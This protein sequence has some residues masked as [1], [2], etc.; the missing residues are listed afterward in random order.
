MIRFLEMHP[1]WSC[2]EDTGRCFI[3]LSDINK[4]MFWSKVQRKLT[5]VS[6][7][8]EG[9]GEAPPEVFAD[10]EKRPPNFRHIMDQ[11]VRNF[12]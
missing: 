5:L 3:E 9:G 4:G 11:I 10:S 2:T 6:G 7:R 12:W 8:G 1:K